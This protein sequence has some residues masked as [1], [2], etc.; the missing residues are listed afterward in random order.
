M[1]PSCSAPRPPSAPGD[2]RL[3]LRR[4]AAP[5]APRGPGRSL[6]PRAFGWASGNVRESC[7]CLAFSPSSAVPI[8]RPI[9]VADGSERAG[10]RGPFRAPDLT[11][12]DSRRNLCQ[13]A[14]LEM[15]SIRPESRARA[16]S[17]VHEAVRSGSASQHGGRKAGNSSALRFNAL[18]G[19][20]YLLMTPRSMRHRRAVPRAR[21]ACSRPT[22]CR[23]VFP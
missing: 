8:L 18:A 2:L 17:S 6:E 23:V 3:Q 5:E 19:G 11:S 4:L 12:V 20:G 9:G 1:V 22:D 14:A 21:V 13:E 10:G 16:W 7:H 15:T